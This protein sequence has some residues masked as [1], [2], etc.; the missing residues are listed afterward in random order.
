VEEAAQE[1]AGRVAE[2]GAPLRVEAQVGDT[3][4]AQDGALGRVERVIRSEAYVP[5]YLVVAARGRVRRRYPILPWSL[6]TRVDR[7]T[8]RVHVRGRRG[9]LGD[10]S[11][12]LPIVL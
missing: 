5:A 2:D 12:A 1:L 3:V 11:E 7:S 10:M 8:R 4:V 9:R 6:V